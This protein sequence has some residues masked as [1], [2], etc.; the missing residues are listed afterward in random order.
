MCFHKFNMGHPGEER[1][2][3]RTAEVDSTERI[4]CSSRIRGSTPHSPTTK[5][6]AIM[7]RETETAVENALRLL[8]GTIER[9]IEDV[10][11]VLGRYESSHDEPELEKSRSYQA[12]VAG[13]YYLGRAEN[14]IHNQLN[15]QQ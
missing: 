5:N 11:E 6:H 10:S 12:L 3:W 13:A 1:P 15:K 14:G 2:P 7:K 4:K 8:M 9:N